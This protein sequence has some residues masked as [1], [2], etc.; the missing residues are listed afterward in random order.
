MSSELLWNS[1]RAVASCSDSGSLRRKSR[2][3][4]G[5]GEQRRIVER[6]REQPS[7]RSQGAA[8]DPQ[9]LKEARSDYWE[10]S[11]GKAVRVRRPGPDADTESRRRACRPRRSHPSDRGLSDRQSSRTNSAMSSRQTAKAREVAAVFRVQPA[12]A[13]IEEEDLVARRRDLRTRSRIPAAVALDAVQK[14][15]L[16]RRRFAR[17]RVAAIVP[18][19]AV[20]AV[21]TCSVGWPGSSSVFSASANQHLLAQRQSID[22]LFLNADAQA[23]SARSPAPSRPSRR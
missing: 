8:A 17:R 4:C 11:R 12:A 9:A 21:V 10:R 14:D 15:R 20:D 3:C 18:A 13:A 1:I 19:I 2:H 23:R 16:A 5:L 6:D 7:R 22:A